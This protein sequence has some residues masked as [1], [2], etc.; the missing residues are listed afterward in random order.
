MVFHWHLGRA[1]RSLT[2]ARYLSSSIWLAFTAIL[3][4]VSLTSDLSVSTAKILPA[5]GPE[6]GPNM[7]FGKGNGINPGRV[8][9]A[10]NP[11]ATNENCK[12]VIDNGDWYFNP[13]KCR[14]EGNQRNGFG[15]RKKDKRKIRSEEGME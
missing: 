11:A 13:C 8:I 12:N 6:D 1:W 7:P 3:S 15:I 2:A 14:S 4:V 9:W 5:T 10:W